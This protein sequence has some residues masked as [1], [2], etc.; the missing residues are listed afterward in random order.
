MQRTIIYY[1]SATGNSLY[2]AREL[3]DAIDNVVLRSIPADLRDERFEADAE[4]VGFVFPLHYFGLPMVVEEFLRRVDVS[5]AQYIFA[6]A[7]CGVP[8][9][10]TPF[11]AMNELL[12]EQ[13]KEV[14]AAWFVRLVSNYIPMRDIPAGWRISIRAWMARR[15]LKKII[16]FVEAESAHPVWQWLPSALEHYHPDW[17][18][19]REK[20]DE[21]FTCDTEKCI[22]CG[23]CER[24]C[25]V[26]N[27]KRPE[28]SP[29]WQHNCT[30]CLGCLHIC[31]KHAID[32]GTKTSGRHLYRHKDI[33]AQDLL[34]PV[35]S[36]ED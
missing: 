36:D 11:T 6:V 10:G 18:E 33:G 15:M 12:A 22:H 34:M 3:R 20:I 25:P 9:N 4:R 30:E 16:A 5:K 13:G 29:V 8:F 35:R 28:G 17:L 26:M 2:V 1:F 7:T 23:L 21:A 24:V 14:G 19:R 32:Y 31:P 27:I